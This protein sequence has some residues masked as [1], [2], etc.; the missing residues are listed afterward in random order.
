VHQLVIKRFQL[1]KM[2]SW[3]PIKFPDSDTIYWIISVR[4]F[5]NSLKWE[6]WLRFPFTLVQPIQPKHLFRWR[7]RTVIGNWETRRRW[8]SDK[9]GTEHSRHFHQ[10]AWVFPSSSA[11]SKAVS[12]S[13]PVL[14]KTA[15]G[16]KAGT[17]NVIHI[18]PLSKSD[19]T[20]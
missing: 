13:V 11:E 17:V 4:I 12:G 10:Y 3:Q 2:Y 15:S 19:I 5:Q 1:W 6:S 18:H 9:G 8:K 16:R 20:L 7:L 14:Y